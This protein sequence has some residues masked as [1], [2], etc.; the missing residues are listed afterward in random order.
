[1]KSTNN[2]Y[3]LCELVRETY[4]SAIKKMGFSPGQAFAY[5]Y[6]YVELIFSEGKFQKLCLLVSLFCCAKE[7][8]IDMNIDDLFTQDVLGE[9]KSEVDGFDAGINPEYRDSRF[10]D[11]DFQADL[12]LVRGSFL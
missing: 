4:S 3:N 12:L 10:T 9:L 7:G 2:Y 6:D 1:M 11:A 5:T 8:M